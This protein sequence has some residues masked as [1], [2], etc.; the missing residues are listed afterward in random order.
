[1]KALL[2]DMIDFKKQR[3]VAEAAAFFGFYAGLFLLVS[4]F[5][6]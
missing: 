4:A 6:G 1:M 3:S 5:V 2:K